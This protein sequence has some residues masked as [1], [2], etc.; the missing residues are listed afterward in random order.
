MATNTEGCGNPKSQ[1]AG[2][3]QPLA[4][5]RGPE[6]D[7][8]GEEN[9]CFLV[10]KYHTST[11]KCS[12]TTYLDLNIKQLDLLKSN[13]D[14]ELLKLHSYIEEQNSPDKILVHVDDMLPTE[15]DV[16]KLLSRIRQIF[17]ESVKIRTR[18]KSFSLPKEMPQKQTEM[19]KSF[20]E[21]L[22]IYYNDLKYTME[23]DSLIFTT[24]PD[25]IDKIKLL[26]TQVI[27][28]IQST[29]SL[30]VITEKELE[31]K[32]RSF[33]K[34]H[35]DKYCVL[36]IRCQ[37]LSCSQKIVL[38]EKEEVKMTTTIFQHILGSSEEKEEFQTELKKLFCH[39]KFQ[40][41]YNGR[42]SLDA[43]SW[44]N[45]MQ[46]KQVI[47]IFDKFAKRYKVSLVSNAT[48][49]FLREKGYYF[50]TLTG[51]P[52]YSMIMHTCEHDI[53]WP[54]TLICHSSDKETRGI[55]DSTSDTLITDDGVFEKTVVNSAELGP[56]NSSLKEPQS[57][58]TLGHSSSN[59][60]TH[61]LDV[62]NSSNLSTISK[63][64][65]TSHSTDPQTQAIDM[66]GKSYTSCDDGKTEHVID[67]KNIIVNSSGISTMSHNDHN[68]SG[69]I[70]PRFTVE[71]GKSSSFNVRQADIKCKPET[72]QLFKQKQKVWQELVKLM[73]DKQV[74]LTMSEHGIIVRPDTMESNVTK[75]IADTYGSHSIDVNQFNIDPQKV[76]SAV[77]QILNSVNFTEAVSFE[78]IEDKVVFFG[79]I[80][81]LEEML[82]SINTSKKPLCLE[83]DLDECNSNVDRQLKLEPEY[84]SFFE[85]KT[86][87]LS[88]INKS[89]IGIGDKTLVVGKGEDLKQAE[90]KFIDYVSKHMTIIKVEIPGNG[91]EYKTRIEFYL[92]E[93]ELLDKVLIIL[94]DH[95]LSMVG[96]KL[97]IL[98]MIERE[99]FD[100]FKFHAFDLSNYKQVITSIRADDSFFGDVNIVTKIK[101]GILKIGGCPNEVKNLSAKVQEC[102]ALAEDFEVVDNVDRKPLPLNPKKGDVEKPK[103]GGSKHSQTTRSTSTSDYKEGGD[104]DVEK[105][106]HRGSKQSQTTRSTSTSIDHRDTNYSF[107]L[108]LTSPSDCFY[109]CQS[110]L[111]RKSELERCFNFSLDLKPIAIGTK[112]VIFAKYHGKN[113]TLIKFL[114]GETI[115]PY[116]TNEVILVLCNRPNYDVQLFDNDVTLFK[117]FKEQSRNMVGDVLKI[118]TE[119]DKPCLAFIPNY[120]DPEMKKKLSKL[121]NEFNSLMKK[122]HRYKSVTLLWDYYLED[123]NNIMPYVLRKLADGDGPFKHLE[124][125]VLIPKGN[126]LSDVKCEIQKLLE[127]D[128]LDLNAEG[129]YIEIV[130]GSIEKQAVDVIVN[131]TGQDLVLSKGNIS[132][133]ILQKVGYQIQT[134]C[135][136][137]GLSD[138]GIAVTKGGKYFKHIFHVCLPSFDS[139]KDPMKNLSVVVWNCLE[140]ANCRKMTSIAFPVLGIGNLEYPVHLVAKCMLD[141]INEYFRIIKRR[142]LCHVMIVAFDEPSQQAFY[143]ENLLRV[144]L[145]KIAG[146]F[147]HKVE[148]SIQADEQNKDEIEQS[149]KKLI[150]ER[151]LY[152]ACE[153]SSEN[154]EYPSDSRSAATEDG[155]MDFRNQNRPRNLQHHKERCVI[156]TACDNQFASIQNLLTPEFVKNGIQPMCFI[157]PFEGNHNR[158]F[159]AFKS[160]EDRISACSTETLELNRMTSETPKSI[161]NDFSCHVS[162]PPNIKVKELKLELEK[163]SGVFVEF[164]DQNEIYIEGCEIQIHLAE[165]MLQER[166]E[167]KSKQT[168]S[169]E[170]HGGARPK[171]PTNSSSECKRHNLNKSVFKAVHQII[172]K[173]TVQ[174]VSHFAEQP[175]GS[176]DFYLLK[177]TTDEA[178]LKIKDL[179]ED[180][181]HEEVKIPEDKMDEACE[182]SEDHDYKGS[183]YV[184]VDDDTS[185]VHILGVDF[186]EVEEIVHKFKIAVGLLKITNKKLQRTRDDS[187]S[188]LPP[189]T[190][191]QEK[192]FNTSS[193]NIKVIVKKSDITKLNVDVIV[194]AANGY[195]AHGA[196]VAYH[197]SKAGGYRLNQECQ[198]YIKK[199]GQIP[200]T[201]ICKTTGGDMRC[202][203]VYHAVGP[204]WDDYRGNKKDCEDD[205]CK[206]IIRCLVEADKDG[207]KSIAIP[208]ISSAIFGVPKSICVE[209]YVRAV[210]SFDNLHNVINLR[211]IYFVDIQKDMVSSIQGG[212]EMFLKKP[213]DDLQKQTLGRLI[214]DIAGGTRYGDMDSTTSSQ[215]KSS[216]PGRSDVAQSQESQLKMV[217]KKQESKMIC[218]LNPDFSIHIYQS[219]AITSSK[220]DAITTWEDTQLSNFNANIKIIIKE[221][222]QIYEDERTEIKTKTENKFKAGS[223][224]TTSA[225]SLPFK[226][227]FHL[228]SSIKPKEDELESLIS[229]LLEETRKTSVHSVTTGNGNVDVSM[230]FDVL[231]KQLQKNIEMKISSTLKEIH[232]VVKSEAYMTEFHKL[233]QDLV[234]QED[235]KVRKDEECSICME[236]ISNRKNLPCG[237]SFCGPCIDQAMKL[238]IFCPVCRQNVYGGIQTG[239]QPEGEM[240]VT[241][242]KYSLPGYDRYGTIEINYIFRDGIQ[243]EK[244]PNPGKPFKGTTRTAYL[245]DNRDGQEVLSLLK[246][247]WER[248]LIF[249]VGK[250]VT[251]GQN[252]VVTWNDIHHKTRT[253]G[254]P[255]SFGYPDSRYLKRVKGELMAHG[256]TSEKPR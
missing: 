227:I 66:E 183:V 242:Y 239:T 175:D 59:S 23:Q 204:R 167:N 236:V 254:G 207:Y 19:L 130:P 14:S 74:L 149:L 11:E 63:Y 112:D 128:S 206:T 121:G 75:Y 122:G 97:A 232:L 171:V 7:E 251:T 30:K 93:L 217:I 234:H 176:V 92:K 24:T 20:E 188:S 140:E 143:R 116:D 44:I 31:E 108:T 144:R 240:K 21:Q 115:R 191:L 151:Q 215:I 153:D 9:K 13:I 168:S 180:I 212:F 135:Y 3:H 182:F 159:I 255:D 37:M 186:N 133:A 129:H 210:N 141:E 241:T 90:D 76:Y 189:Q 38:L 229:N 184:G 46:I 113:G 110:S 195:M 98:T 34:Q 165:T 62:S 158:A 249:T 17:K 237:H 123:P 230:L 60:E 91:F 87:L 88:E 72:I 185:T 253:D 45:K 61:D 146:D 96:Q 109:I 8:G 160:L 199:Y 10:I 28:K 155:E 226:Y 16:Q 172:G 54:L 209:M 50:T 181:R 164:I 224:I 221:A 174:K 145:C 79:H 48:C 84:V 26:A 18:N 194:N 213:L 114:V 101:D 137:N 169:G 55:I 150:K 4:E 1:I 166:L 247:A 124:K 89:I 6:F 218:Y 43:T 190:E 118:L 248:R 73:E 177:S 216:K 65:Q 225:G 162:I 152:T 68:S 77:H 235:D 27:G 187:F 2:I 138:K 219:D 80:S 238:S 102:I 81:T 67:I 99:S 12:D 69:S 132:N 126:S 161:I 32:K 51:D 105:P 103:H 107:T 154:L 244:H 156:V 29:S 136:R 233:H 203:K 47:D 41:T 52:D 64:R 170:Y 85:K 231:L 252:D 22:K 56:K 246:T 222:G 127:R 95:C 42:V 243:S 198:D 111:N 35:E 201:G 125:T 49:E 250:S 134:E 40:S 202:N 83:T 223:V 104:Y 163:A 131:S 119:T 106:K 53:K 139:I 173:E 205:L 120:Q 25:M 117:K 78:I 178:V 157:T 94:K 193:K 86:K 192:T 228:V 147:V 148:V 245:P 208:S 71:T 196:G 33:R 142:H 57:K 36:D 39:L 200:V 82:S 70:S 58:E 197:I 5:R 179:I 15:V 220:T 214:N 211:E 256:V 100:I